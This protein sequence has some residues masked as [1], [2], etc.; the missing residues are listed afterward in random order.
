M[1]FNQALK[2]SYMVLFQLPVLPEI[3]LASKDWRV[4]TGARAVAPR[5]LST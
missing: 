3:F 4:A 5:R 1:T 2:S